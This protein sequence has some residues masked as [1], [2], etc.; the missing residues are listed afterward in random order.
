MKEDILDFRREHTRGNSDSKILYSVENPKSLSRRRRGKE[1]ISTS[2]T[3][4]PLFQ[5]QEEY[6]SFQVLD[7]EI[8]VEM[9]LLR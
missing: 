2:H 4:R 3:E 6:Y 5:H 8:D 7:L 1:Q 9:S